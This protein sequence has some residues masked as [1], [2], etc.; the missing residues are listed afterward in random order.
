MFVLVSAVPQRESAGYTYLCP[1][2]TPS[3]RPPSSHPSK[4]VRVLSW[5]PCANTASCSC[6][7]VTKLC[8]ILCNPLDYSTTGFPVLPVHLTL[9]FPARVH[10]SVLCIYVS[11]PALQTG[12]SVPSLIVCSNSCLSN[13]WCYPTISFSVAPFFSCPQS[14]LASGCFPVS[15]LFTSGGQSIGA[16]TPALVFSMNIQGW[17]P[18]PLTGVISSLSNKESQESSLAPQFKS[19]DSLALSV[20]YGSTLTSVHDYW[21]NHS[22]D[23]MDFCWQSNVSPF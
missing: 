6:C 13:W 20:L 5:A 10:V 19:I 21:K 22:F 17:F 8:P 2:E 1:P 18:L 15:W 3:P 9:L 11:I 16:S 23:C 12:A 4:A 14:F 7:S